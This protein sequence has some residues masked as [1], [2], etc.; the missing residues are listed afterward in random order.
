MTEPPLVDTRALMDTRVCG[1]ELRYLLT[2]Y[3]LETRTALRLRDLVR[4]CTQDGVTFAGRPSKAVSDALRWEIG[5]GRV[6]RLGRG[7]YVLGDM[8]RST[9]SRVMSSSRRTRER[10]RVPRRW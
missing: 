1:T 6:V 5:R 10:I 2:S 7:I 3:L 4:F 8:P 9:K